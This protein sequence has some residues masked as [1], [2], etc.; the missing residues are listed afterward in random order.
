MDQKFINRIAEN[1]V[2]TY[3]TRGFVTA[4][5]YAERTVGKEGQEVI[6]AVRNRVLEIMHTKTKGGPNAGGTDTSA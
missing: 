1:Y 2:K 5:E 4:A 6:D 3:A